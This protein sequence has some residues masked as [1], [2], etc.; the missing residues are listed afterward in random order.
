MRLHALLIV[1]GCLAAVTICDCSPRARCLAQAASPQA[2]EKG[3]L[4]D[5][6][7]K[8]ITWF[9]TLDYP[10]LAGRRCV[11]VATGWWSRSSDDSAT[12]RYLF[13]FLLSEKGDEF[14]VFWSD[15]STHVFRRTPPRTPEHLRVGYNEVD[16]KVAAAAQLAQLRKP[17]DKEDHWRRFGERLSERGEVFVLARACAANGL[18][19]SAH[20]LIAEAAKMPARQTG[21]APG[22]LV[23]ALSQEIAH[24]RMWQAVVEFGDPAISRKELLERFRFIVKHFPTSEHA[25]RAKE[26]ADLL[27]QMVK[28]DDEHA[29]QGAKALDKLPTRERVA[30][31][32]FR[33]RDQNGHQW[34]QP[35]WCDIFDDF[36]GIKD[37][38][39]TPAH[40][41]VAVGF[42]AVPQLIDVL[43]DR[44]F[45]RSVGFHRDFYFSHHVLRVG[46]CALAI[47]ERIAGRSFYAR[48]TT[49]SEMMKEGQ[50]SEVRKEIRKWWGEVQA[51]GE[52]QVLVEAVGVGDQNAVYQAEQLLKKYPQGA[53]GPIVA[54]AKKQTDG[55]L[56]ARLVDLVTQI[57]G[58]ASSKFLLEEMKGSPC[59]KAA[60]A[61]AHGMLRRGSAEAL[62]A[63][64]ALWE[65]VSATPVSDKTAEGAP[66][67]ALPPYEGTEEVIEFLAGC[68]DPK[69]VDALAKHM[70]AHGIDRRI[71]IVSVFGHGSFGVIS[72]GGG[73]GLSPGKSGPTQ[74]ESV[75]KAVERLLVAAL[76][77]TE[78]REGMSG[79][80]GDKSF[81][82][83]RVCD[84]AAHVLAQRFPKKYRFDLS[85]TLMDRDRQR[86][87]MLNEWRKEQNLSAIPLPQP[88]RIV[89][90]PAT[91][92]EPLL[93]KVVAAG[94]TERRKQAIAELQRLGLPALPA[95]RQRLTVLDAKHAARTDLESLAASMASIVDEVT[96]TEQSAVPSDSLRRAL[97]N[98]KGKPLTGKS[99]V[100][101]LGG[102]QGPSRRLDRRQALG[103]ARRRR[104]RRD[105][106]GRTDQ[107][108]GGWR[109]MDQRGR[110]GDFGSRD[111]G[112]QVY[113]RVIR[114]VQL[115]PW[116]DRGRPPRIGSIRGRGGRGDAGQGFSGSRKH[117]EDTVKCEIGRHHADQRTRH[118]S[119][120]E[121][122]RDGYYKWRSKMRH[123]PTFLAIVLLSS[124]AMSAAQEKGLSGDRIPTDNGVLVIHPV[125]HATL[126]MQWGDKTVYVDPV[127]G[128]K[129]FA[130]LPRPDFVL[131]THM[132]FDHFDPKTLEAVVP[133]SGKTVI[134]APK[135]V[136][137]K[138]PESLR[139][140]VRILT[141]GERTEL[142]GIAVEAVPAYNTTP[143]HEKFHPKGRDNGYV[144][145]MGGKR[146]YVAGDTE[147]TPEMR[148]LKDIDVAFLPMNL[149]YTMSVEMAADAIRQ[150]KPKVVYPYHYRS[151][152]GTKADFDK[153]RKLVGPDSGVEIRVRE[154]YPIEK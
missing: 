65:R 21:E 60:V 142:Q 141:N 121:R 46:D 54:A 102:S 77:D 122:W 75:K 103:R 118:G 105:A 67:C 154:W 10:N 131:V 68:G 84:L 74:K 87:A 135:T 66:P 80:W 76:E 45:T 35:G 3:V 5:A 1:V 98:A 17:P 90:A 145:R 15:L 95:V 119:Y 33:L 11:R 2:A 42:D 28:E 53:L 134:V 125:N 41:L 130:G 116:V 115:R 111:R 31:L 4:T 52:K 149:P 147:D 39:K 14:T 92:T 79:S 106:P 146:V 94:S 20:E 63:M 81:Q 112:S 133:A 6:D 22:D 23:E 109:G 18:E 153:L 143:G 25:A 136:A 49:S 72:S 91:T 13:G 137:E 12:N 93:A 132:H 32:I 73:G 139:G 89:P 129:P 120:D 48:R 83:P 34:S 30:E 144:L 150:F 69:A 16:L 55:Y 126:V 8:A 124:A 29:R 44:R 38:G 108:P 37:G 7:R 36:G 128:G 58:D 62:P 40:R 96:F 101:A 70:R 86:L 59:G 51:K 9:D 97:E 140:M 82:D 100:G 24:G 123:L 127:G 78:Q 47:I 43:D 117:G 19:P 61:A 138:M 110:L 85:A 50:E 151:H 113:S 57:P 152:D 27:A 99:F 88:K 114:R 107:G 26:T 64:I 71:A 148:A 104:H 56:R